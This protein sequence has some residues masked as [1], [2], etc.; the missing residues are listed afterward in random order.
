MTKELSKAIMEK[1]KTRN[2]YLKWTSRDNYVSYKKSKNKCNSLTKKSKKKA[3]KDEIMSNEKFQSTVKPFLTNKGCISNDF[4]SVEKDGDLISNEKE[5]VELFNQNHI[6]IIENSSGKKPSSLGD[7]LNVSQD[8]LTVKENISVYSNHP[9]IQKIKSVFNTDS[10]FD[11][12]K[13]TASDINKIIKSLDPNK[14][15]GPD[16]IPAKFVQMSANVIDCHLSNIIACDISKNKYSEH[17]KIAT[18][19]PVFKEDD[20]TKIK[21]YR[22]VSLLNMF[23]KIYEKF[24]HENLKNYVNIFLSKSISAYCKS[25]STNHVLIRLIKN[26]KKSL[27]EKKFVGA[28]LMDLSK[29]FDFIHHNLLIAK[30]YV[31]G[32]S[33]NVF[34]FFTHT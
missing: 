17:A 26:W 7:C 5:L 23:S 10:K 11:L 30:M 24:L 25:Y 3:T 28:I 4:I 29:A 32:F 20:R 33:M 14:A 1:Q 2:K 9:S 12:P 15:T 21:N 27:D 16:G 19:R 13:P 31:Y 6:N 34:T 18:V 22:P 8:E